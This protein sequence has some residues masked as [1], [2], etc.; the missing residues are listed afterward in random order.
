MLSA[1]L[2]K[3]CLGEVA[4]ILCA[5]AQTEKPIDEK[6]ATGVDGNLAYPYI[7]FT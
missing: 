6:Y 7:R 5:Q 3:V 2:E 4:F 1:F